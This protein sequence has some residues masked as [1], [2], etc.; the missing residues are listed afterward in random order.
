MKLLA[1]H[2][3]AVLAVR[4]RLWPVVPPGGAIVLRYHR[5]GGTPREPVP[6]GV[7]P[8]EFD[9]QLRFLRARCTVVRPSELAAALR[10]ASPLPRNAVAI[11]FDDGYEDN[12]SAALPLLQQHGLSA[13]FFVTVAGLTS[14]GARLA[15]GLHLG[16]EGHARC[17]AGP[18]RVG[19]A[20]VA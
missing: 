20:V 3:A 1:R 13:A 4:A 19:G 2:A 5:V 12:C 7:S 8:Q 10:Q 6:L 18:E 16:R 11:T 14:S 17:G 15:G 9:G